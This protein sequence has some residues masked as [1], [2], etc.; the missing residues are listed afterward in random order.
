MATARTAS[1]AGRATANSAVTEPRVLVVTSS[2]TEVVRCFVIGRSSRGWPW[3][4]PPF[5][6]RR[7]GAHHDV[8]GSE[9]QVQR[10]VDHLTDEVH[11]GCAGHDL[12]Q[13]AGEPAG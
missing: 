13:D 4:A 9:Q 5:D 6:P 11:D 12:V 1:T 8:G 2:A 10:V 7:S 3:C